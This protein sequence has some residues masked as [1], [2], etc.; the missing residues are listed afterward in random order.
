MNH[1]K[2]MKMSFSLSSLQPLSLGLEKHGQAGVA[3]ERPYNSL[4]KKRKDP[5]QFHNQRLWA[6]REDCKDEFWA[7]IRSNYDYI[8]DT[9]LIDSCKEANGELTW[10]E[11]DV[12]TQSWSFKEVSSQF[13]E[14][15]SW[16][17]VLQELVYCKEENLLDKSLRA[18][19]MEELR[20]RAYRR[21]LFN[22]Q[23]GKLVSH[24]PAL[25]DEV[26]WRVDHLNAKWELV[27]QIMAPIERPVSNQ[28]DISADFEHEVKCLRKWLREM[29]SRLQPLSFHI[30]WT[31][32]ELEEKAVEHMVLQ[33]DI[34]AHGRIVSSVV[35]LGDK[36]FTQQQEQQQQQQE[37]QEEKKQQE[38]QEQREPPQALR[39]ARSL[40]RR[41]H[42]L[43]L[44]ALEWQCH[45]ETLVSRISSKN[46]VPY[47][48]SSDSDEEPVT[49]QPR[50]SRRHSRGSGRESPGQSVRSTRSKRHRATRSRYYEDS[51]TS[52]AD[53][54]D[55]DA[56]SEIRSIGDGSYF[57]DELCPLYVMDGKSE[58]TE[59][60]REANRIANTLG[61]Q[62]EEGD[63]EE[64]ALSEDEE[65]DM[66]PTPDTVPMTNS[67]AIVESCDQIDGQPGN[68]EQ[69][70]GN[71]A[72]N[73]PAKRR[74][75]TEEVASFNTSDRKSKNCATFYFRHLDTDS[76]QNEEAAIVA[77]DSSEEE[78]TY[79]SSRTTNVTTEERKTNVV[80]RLDFGEGQS[81]S[82][83]N[84]G[85]AKT[86]EMKPVKETSNME[87]VDETSNETDASSH[88]EKDSDDETRNDKTSI[89]RLIK[90]VEKLVGEER[91]N[92][93]SKTFP[94]L[95]LDDKGISNNH[96][97]KYARIKEWLKLNSARSHEGRSTSQPLD[98]CDASGEYTTEESD[99]ERQSVSSEDLQ[100]S[101]ATYRRFEG[102][103]G[104]TSQSVSQEIFDDA[105]KTPIN[106]AHPMLDTSTPKVVMRPKQKTN[107]PRPWSVTCISQIGNNSNLNQTNDPISQF[108]ISETALHQLIAT[109]PTKSVSLD[110]TGSRK[111]FNNSTSTLL[112]ESIICHDGRVV[113]NSSLRRKKSRLRK[114]NLGRKSDSSSEGVNANHSA[115]SDG[116]LSNQQR[117]P[118]KMSG[119]RTMRTI[120]RDCHGRLT[121]LVKSGSFS[122]CTAH[123]QLSAERTIVSDPT[124]PFRLPCCTSVASTSETEGEEQRNCT[125]GCFTYDDNLLDTVLSNKELCN[126]QL[127]VDSDIEMNSLGNNSFSEQAWD[128]YQEKYMSEPYSE[129]PDVET[130]RRL[131]DF[132]DDYR[133]FLDS[134]SDCASSMSAVPASSPL[135]RS[136]MHHEVTDT[137]EDSDDSDVED[138][139]NVVEKSQAQFT[140][141]ENLFSRSNNGTMP[142]DC[143]E[144]EC[145]CRE[146]LRCLHALLE[147]VSNSFRSEK[148][149]KQVR[150]MLEKWESLTTRVE[151]TQM[152]TALHRELTSL[153]TEFKAAH[154]RLFSY[155]ITLEQPHVL[156]ERIN[157]ITAELAA[158]R[159][160]KAAMLALN[161]ST[162]RLIT[163]L[164]GS[165]SLIFTALKDGVADLY[166]VWDE[167]FQ[168]GNQ[169]LCALQAVQQFSIRL[170]ELQCALR[171]DK[172]TLAVLDVALQAGATSEVASSVRHVARLLSEKQ[173]I[174]CQNGTVLKDTTTEEVSSGATTKFGDS[175]P[176]SL[177][178]EGGSLSDS[179]ISDSGSEQELSERERRLAALRRLT[180]SLESQLAPG[181]EAL[182]ELLKR[183]EDA[184]TELRDLQKQCRELIVRTAASVEARAVKRTSSQVHHCADKR[185]KP[186]ATEM[187]KDSAEG[188]MALVRAKSGATDGGDPDNE[189]GLPHSWVWRVLRAALPFQLALVALFWAACLLEPHCCE[190]A[191][192][193]NLSLTPQLRYVRGPPPV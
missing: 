121:T 88:R 192:T 156:D 17:R 27:E 119:S 157:R 115:G 16:L 82:R 14:L 4:T 37:G 12:S 135:P 71:L 35:K 19:H 36:V 28:Q 11:T 73:E 58:G 171:R 21:K 180:R 146:N 98:S 130:A 31:L 93:A 67:T 131:L 168:K 100:S 18:A 54:S 191:N 184:E 174:S 181:S 175:S 74:R 25:K 2:A 96:R 170:A 77:E 122:G 85:N 160:R 166:R 108:S 29:E 24:A 78:W 136:R 142:E 23:A 127:N 125:R 103:L 32:A 57:E 161:V 72:A 134:Q 109:P 97:A 132:G 5:K 140:L 102:A 162:H 173:D 105:D 165:A 186:G 193:L 6:N 69:S 187:S 155:E 120:S 20:R 169:Q 46:L 189:P 178:Q 133:N 75:T 99:G 149:V 111:S 163:D 110:A 62:G 114:K 26:A 113:R 45:I 190:A 92:G 183:V 123:Q 185:K 9:N 50:L 101:V 65:D 172:D 104:C 148:Y 87:G 39:I 145:A 89:Q 13:S 144:V 147:S 177:T 43:F 59:N 158:L 91:R 51:A 182:V 129:A 30:D 141:A 137:T 188:R 94:Q 81:E 63:I 68:V 86:S 143:T 138:I 70:N 60:P 154:D 38:Q 90:E 159:D 118:R 15:Y 41:W 128:N 8:M 80:V 34:E 117:S 124:P 153:R 76:E 150:G 49:K 48:C 52:R 53:L 151:E 126:Q 66:P 1:C 33:R 44:R 7:A 40:E 83:P 139:R 22:E 176:I 3:I 106:E 164:G 112:E 10:D 152:A 116:S 64:G 84:E 42:L 47:R 107:G 61:D 167:T 95:I 56:S 179:G 79:T 55:T